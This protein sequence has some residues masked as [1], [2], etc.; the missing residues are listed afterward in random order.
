LGLRLPSYADRG[1]IPEPVD[2]VAPFAEEMH[3]FFGTPVASLVGADPHLED[4]A[5]V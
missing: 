4:C 1:A 5:M 3:D 2:V